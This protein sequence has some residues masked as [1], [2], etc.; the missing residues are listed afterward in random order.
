[1]CNGTAWCAGVWGY[2]AGGAHFRVLVGSS[3]QINQ[4]TTITKT[5]GAMLV[6]AV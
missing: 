3:V 5:N 4:P 2:E 1:M 6:V